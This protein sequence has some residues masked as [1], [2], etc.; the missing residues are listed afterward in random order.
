VKIGT[1]SLVVGTAACNAACGYCVSKMTGHAA[2][3]LDVN[4][5]RFDV[6]CRLAQQCGVTTTLLTGKGEPTLWPDLILDYLQRLDRYRM[7]VVELQTNGTLL[8]AGQ[9]DVRKWASIGLSL[10][11]LSIT[12]YDARSSNQLMQIRDERFDYWEIVKLLHNLGLSV[13]LNCTMLRN[14]IWQFDQIERL[15]DQ[16]RDHGVE[17]LTLRDV[18]V[19][20]RCVN[21]TVTEYARN[22]RVS[23]AAY[24]RGCLEMQGAVQLLHLPHGAIV[25][26]YHGQNV[27]VNNCLT[28]STDPDTMRQIIFFPDGRIAYDWTYPGARLL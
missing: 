5:R 27:C 11:C 13:R 2:E 17:Q 10:V 7:P 8:E 23:A 21:K 25:Y 12:H 16:C 24:V 28:T 3:R 4:W 14:G 26:D 15:I 20:N 22:Q 9:H 18:V 1:L 19:P 6:A